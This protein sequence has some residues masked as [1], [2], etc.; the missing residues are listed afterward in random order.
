MKELME[1]KYGYDAYYFVNKYGDGT[2]NEEFKKLRELLRGDNN[3]QQWTINIL[4]NDNRYCEKA[5]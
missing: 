5:K 1:I 2:H 4:W 3:E